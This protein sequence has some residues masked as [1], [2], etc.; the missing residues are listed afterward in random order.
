M[1]A[2]LAI[3]IARAH[4]APLES[5]AEAQVEEGGI[6]GDRSYGTDRPLTI[7]AQGELD[8]AAAAWGRRILAG[9][10]RRNVTVALPHLP[11]EAGTRMRLGE[12]EVEI[13]GDCAPCG[14][15]EK[16]IGVG[17]KAALVGRAGVEA[18][19]VVPGLLRVG[20]AVSLM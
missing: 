5:L 20:A 18:K 16:A 15:M 1:S 6:V 13:V 19:V 14:L 10:T 8:A 9:S 4:G 2:I 3:H 11:R 7:V 12:V 17:A